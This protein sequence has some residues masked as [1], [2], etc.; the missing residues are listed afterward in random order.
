MATILMF[1]D[2]TVSILPAGYSAYAGYVDGIYENINQVRAR[3]PQAHILTI[4]VKA[5]DI[6]DALD[7]ETGDAVNSD[8]PGWFK[9]A[10]A[11]GIE[12]PCLYTSADNVNTLV[13]VMAK[14][15]IPRTAFRIW[16][17]HYGA[18]EHLCG[19]TTCRA[20]NYPA[21]ATQFTSHAMGQNLDESVCLDEFFTV[22]VPKTPGLPVLT[23]GDTDATE[24]GAVTTLQKRLNAWHANPEVKVDGSFGPAT[25]AAVENFQ[26]ARKIT[27]DG[28]VGPQTWAALQKTPPVVPF[29]T[30]SGLKAVNETIVTWNAVP[31]V[32]GKSPSGYKVEVHDG[33]NVVQSLTSPGTS[34]TIKGLTNSKAY[35]VYVSALGG[36]GTPGVAKIA[37]TA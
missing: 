37:I 18:G 2:V 34:V 22:N 30:P 16:S 1:D 8:A 6:A 31:A 32:N 20:T 25:F 28:V 15:G 26:R 23:T 21:D 35:E 12:R 29:A 11:A 5:A 13:D 33:A 36:E 3:F 27:V 10:L 4:A 9:R 17:A 14:A 7:I 24:K 19:P